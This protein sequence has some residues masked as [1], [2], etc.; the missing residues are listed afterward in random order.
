MPFPEALRALNHRDFRF[1]WGG[2]LVSLIGTW[3]QSVAQSWLVLQLSGSPLKLGLIGTFQFAPVLM[4]SV[5]A[6]AIVDR[7]PKRRLILATQSALALQTSAVIVNAW[8]ARARP[9]LARRRP[10]APPRLRERDRHADAP[11]L[12]RRDGR[13]GRP[14]ERGRPQLRRIQRR[15]HRGPGGGRPPDRPPRRG[16]RVPAERPLVPRG[17]RRAAPRPR[18]GHAPAAHGRDG[19][20]GGPGR[21]PLRARHVADRAG[22]RPRAGRK[23]L[24][25]QLHDRRPPRRAEGARAGRRGV[26]LP[27][28]SARDRRRHGG[29]VPG[30]PR[31]PPDP[32]PH[33]P[34]RGCPLLPGAR[35]ARDRR[36]LPHGRRAPL[37]ARL[38]LDCLHGKLQHHAAALRTRRAPRSRD[39]LLHARLRRRVPARRVHDRRDRRGAGGSDGPRRGRERGA[40]RHGRGRSRVGVYT[41]A[42]PSMTGC[43]TRSVVTLTT[44]ASRLTARPMPRVTLASGG[45]GNDVG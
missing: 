35:G 7:L 28:G 5:V 9:V 1:F 29:A 18:G 33:D 27:H 2:Q 17:D 14:R 24:R 15:T 10:G 21:A 6:G 32:A 12:R 30:D 19:E 4:F 25:L 39:E 26:R 43:L 45:S 11:G 22:P 37:P 3:M 41:Y 42:G 8:R 40:R 13:E 34:P 36:R 44:T 31:R 16:P 38:L 23:S 20:P